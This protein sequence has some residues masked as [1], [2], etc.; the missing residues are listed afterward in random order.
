MFFL[1][2]AFWVRARVHEKCFS[3]LV[4]GVREGGREKFV[5]H[6]NSVT[7]QYELL[8]HTFIK[9]I[10]YKIHVISLET[11]HVNVW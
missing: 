2:C 3:R 9:Y 7:F 10:E 4:S 5:L 1:V 8:K 6:L 11:I